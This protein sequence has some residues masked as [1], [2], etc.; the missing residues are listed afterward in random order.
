MNDVVNETKLPTWAK[1]LIGFVI[2]AVVSAII[3]I[4]VMIFVFQQAFKQAQD[5]KQIANVAQQVMVMQQPLPDG[6]KYLMGFGLGGIN[7]ISIQHAPDQQ[8]LI[9]ISYPC[10]GTE[11]ANDLVAKLYQSGVNTPQSQA[12]FQEVKT[13]GVEDVGGQKMPYIVG[14]MSDKSNTKFEGMVGCIVSKD[15][16][17]SLLIYGIEPPGVPYKLDVTDNL[18]KTIKSF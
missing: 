1:F 15:K 5:P 13:K 3:F 8:M 17:K 7:T 12:E 11:D 10:K 9:F 2:V 4:A 18:L 6:Y 14:V 16:K